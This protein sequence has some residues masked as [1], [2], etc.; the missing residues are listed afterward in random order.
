[1]NRSLWVKKEMKKR[2]ENEI[3]QFLNFIQQQQKQ[4][5]LRHYIVKYLC[6]SY[7]FKVNKEIQS[8]TMICQ[9]C[10]KKQ[11]KKNHKMQGKIV[12]HLIVKLKLK[13]KRNLQWNFTI[14]KLI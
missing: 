6:S 3:I 1:M 10:L 12:Q 11:M 7:K 8:Y 14:W 2:W 4:S 13:L 9:E 5:L